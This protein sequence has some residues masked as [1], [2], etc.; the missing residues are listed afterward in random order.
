MLYV[1]PCELIG[2][3]SVFVQAGCGENDFIAVLNLK[4]KNL[5]LGVS[6]CIV[7]YIT[8]NILHFIEY[9]RRKTNAVERV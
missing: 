4:I 1:N 5:S 9:L 6:E 7:N 3:F 2:N 8:Q